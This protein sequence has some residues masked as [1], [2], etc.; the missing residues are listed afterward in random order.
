MIAA[1]VEE[2]MKYFAV[3]C[4]RQFRPLRSPHAVL[5]CLMAAALGFATSENIEYVFGS[6]VGTSQSRDAVFLG[7]ITTLVAR[8]LMPVHVICS[9]LQAANFS[10]V[11]LNMKYMST[12]LVLLPAIVLHGSFDFYLFVIGAVSFINQDESDG[13]VVASLLGPI[14]ITIAGIIWACRSFGSVV[15]EYEQTL[16]P[17]MPPSQPQFQQQQ[18]PFA[19]P[20]IISTAPTSISS[21]FHTNQ[22]T[23]SAPYNASEGAT[24][25]AGIA[26]D[27]F[28]V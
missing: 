15:R 14:L 4:C 17:P 27:A 13:L 23:S 22:P 21:P 18:Y 5:V 11:V 7:E 10:R 28:F 19:T 9:V 8:L 12:P 2:T 3:K 20:V 16:S 6:P 24:K 1:G 26:N 25:S